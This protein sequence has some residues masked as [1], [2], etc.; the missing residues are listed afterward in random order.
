MTGK[1]NYIVSHMV[2]CLRVRQVFPDSQ[3]LISIPYNWIPIITQ[4]LSELTWEPAEFIMDRNTFIQRRKQVLGE[5]S[6][7]LE[8]PRA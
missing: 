3:V 2:Y 1:V 7:E 8:N 5:V 4:N 6:E